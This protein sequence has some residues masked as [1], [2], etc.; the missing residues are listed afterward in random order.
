MFKRLM[1]GLFALSLAAIWV[2]EANAYSSRRRRSVGVTVIGGQGGDTFVTGV[3][4]LPADEGG[5]CG[6]V[7][8]ELYCAENGSDEARQDCNI[9]T[10]DSAALVVVLDKDAIS[11]G[12]PPNHFT[13]EEVNFYIKAFGQREQLRGF[14]TRA[15]SPD[16]AVFII[17]LPAGKNSKTAGWHLITDLSTWN[18]GDSLTDDEA[19]RRFVG[20]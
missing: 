2:S 17:D 4:G 8:G 5:N 9:A 16:P 12:I 10:G 18:E 19:L 11:A 14:A 3:F 13:E 7:R 1:I 20:T 15:F 6:E